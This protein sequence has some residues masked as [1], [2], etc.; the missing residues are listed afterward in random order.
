MARAILRKTIQ[1]ARATL[2]SH[3]PNLV[4]Y[5]PADNGIDCLSTPQIPNNSESPRFD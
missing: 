2:L 5:R 3:K 4:F 1:S